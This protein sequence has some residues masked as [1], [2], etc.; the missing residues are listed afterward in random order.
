MS[1][2][3]SFIKDKLSKLVNKYEN[4]KFLL[5]DPFILRQKYKIPLDSDINLTNF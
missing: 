2:R 1:Y 5:L 4:E 3:K